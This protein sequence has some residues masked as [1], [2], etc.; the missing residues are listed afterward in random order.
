VSA[1]GKVTVLL[2]DDHAVV[3]EG[4]RRLLERGGDIV[5]VGEASNAEDAH[6]LFSELSPQVVADVGVSRTFAGRVRSSAITLGL[7]FDLP[8]QLG[9]RGR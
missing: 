5:V 8:V 7:S 6:K 9:G 4:Y 3:R 2:V 1:P